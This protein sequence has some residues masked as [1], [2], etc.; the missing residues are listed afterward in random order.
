MSFKFVDKRHIIFEYEE[1]FQEEFNTSFQDY[2]DF[3]LSIDY[4]FLKTIQGIN[5]L[6]VPK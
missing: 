5:Y 1:Q 4:K 2:V 6:I 3:V